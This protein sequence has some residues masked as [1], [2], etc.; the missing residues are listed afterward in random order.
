M[1]KPLPIGY[2]NFKEVISEGLV[3]EGDDQA[4]SDIVSEQL[5]ET[6]SFFDYA[7]RIAVGGA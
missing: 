7:E 2:D 1:K 3:Q 4:F 6:I 5:V